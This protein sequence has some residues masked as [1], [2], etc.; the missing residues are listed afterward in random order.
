MQNADAPRDW[1]P[2]LPCT[3]D[4]KFIRVLRIAKPVNPNDQE[5]ICNIKT[6]NIA[7]DT[8]VAALSYVWGISPTFTKA[9]RCN[10][11]IVAVGTNCWSALWHLR[12]GYYSDDPG[13]SGGSL[14][15][16]TIWVDSIC[17]DQQDVKEKE[18]QLRLMADIYSLARQVYVWLGEGSPESDAA[19]E[20]LR[21][22]GFQ[23]ALVEIGENQYEIPRSNLFYLRQAWKMF[24]CQMANL[25]ALQWKS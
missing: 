10:G 17:I 6:I 11:N 15:I 13:V 23:E 25:P 20:Y 14:D 2:P 12:N 22:A 21:K 1:L 9:I 8:S 7:Q 24:T 18:S 3:P 4:S 19:I 16:M 5:I